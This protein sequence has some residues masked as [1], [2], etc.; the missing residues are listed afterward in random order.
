M[1]EFKMIDTM[2]KDG[3]PW[4]EAPIYALVYDVPNMLALAEAARHYDGTDLYQY[5]SKKSGAGIKSVIDGYLL[6]GFPLERTGIG[7]G[8]VRQAT[9]GDGGTS[10]N[11][12]GTMGKDPRT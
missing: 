3:G 2:L 12:S 7:Q 10:Y 5:V 1:G 11:P 4:A 9:F 8:R 6:M